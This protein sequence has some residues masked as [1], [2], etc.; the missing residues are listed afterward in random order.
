MLEEDEQAEAGDGEAG[1]E[2]RQ[3]I[4]RNHRPGKALSYCN[5]RSPAITFIQ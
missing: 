5:A 2:K 1:G 4:R 3:G